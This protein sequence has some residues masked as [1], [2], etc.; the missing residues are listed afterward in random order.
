MLF[1]CCEI[2]DIDDWGV[3]L[4]MNGDT[5][6]E[7][8]RLPIGRREG[9]LAIK[10]RDDSRSGDPTWFQDD[11]DRPSSS[12]LWRCRAKSAPKRE[13]LDARGDT[14]LAVPEPVIPR[15]KSLFP[16]LSSCS[17]RDNLRILSCGVK[18]SSW[19]LPGR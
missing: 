19:R 13:G 14:T 5:S 12:F 1:S 6:P 15:L 9:L 16:E 2:I 18:T 4:D 3:G 11:A 7:I 8:G 10:L 17:V